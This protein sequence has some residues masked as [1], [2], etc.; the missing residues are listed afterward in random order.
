MKMPFIKV[1]SVAEVPPETAIEV[2][3]GDQPYAICNTGGRIRA[4]SGVCIHRG[5]PLGQGQIE[6]GHVLCPYHLWAFDCATGAYDYDPSKRVPTFEVKV[7]D[8]DIYLLMP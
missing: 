7:D 6:N 2:M 1:A 8:G 5:G 4:L 3:V